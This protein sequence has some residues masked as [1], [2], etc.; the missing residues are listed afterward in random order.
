MR[1]AQHTKGQIVVELRNEKKA[2]AQGTYAT[3]PCSL[4]ANNIVPDL[5]VVRSGRR[6]ACQVE[7]RLGRTWLPCYL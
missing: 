7:I 2:K 6:Q 3:Q 4:Q 1:D 5:A